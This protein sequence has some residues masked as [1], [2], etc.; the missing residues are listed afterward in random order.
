MRK[1]FYLRR[2]VGDSMLPTFKP[3]DIVLALPL[4]VRPGD[5]VVALQAGREV[6]KRVKHIKRKQYVI[7]GDNMAKSSDSRQHGPVEKQDLSGRVVFIFPK[8]EEPVSPRYALGK[9]L[10]YLLFIV[11]LVLLVLQFADLPGFINKV[12]G[13][14]PG[15]TTSASW[16]SVGLL[17]TELFALPYLVLV[18]L[19]PLGHIVSGY[20]SVLAPLWWALVLIW[21]YGQAQPTGIFGRAANQA[22][23]KWLLIAVLVWLVVSYLNLWLRNYEKQYK[24]LRLK[25]K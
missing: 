24:R 11:L 4:R 21:S 20:L 18:R 15:S 19:S 22:S 6:I 7:I 14:M 17:V 16:I 23:V 1:P 5:V 9:W 10:S 8:S 2:V 13:I 25:L 3:G 12:N